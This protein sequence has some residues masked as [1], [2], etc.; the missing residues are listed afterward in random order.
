MLKPE[1]T[2]INKG[3]QLD[4]ILDELLHRL[5]DRDVEIGAVRVISSL[6]LKRKE[7]N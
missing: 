2:S 4:L 7:N 6:Y 3:V 5:D 1:L